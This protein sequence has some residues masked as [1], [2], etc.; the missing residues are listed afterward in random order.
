MP[1]EMINRQNP[2]NGFNRC[3]VLLWCEAQREIKSKRK[4]DAINSRLERGVS[5]HE[6]GGEGLCAHLEAVEAV[7]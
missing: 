6:D 3:R 7:W 5:I 4:R 2:S 1:P